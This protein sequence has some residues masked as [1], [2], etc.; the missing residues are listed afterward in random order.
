MTSVSRVLVVLLG[1][2]FVAGAVSASADSPDSAVRGFLA[3][4]YDGRFDELPKAPAARTERFERQVRNILRVRYI[5]AEQVAITG[6]EE[7]PD[8]ATLHADVAIAKHDRHGSGAWSSVEIVPLRFEL[9]RQGETWLVAE[10]RNRD[11]ELADHLLQASGEERERLRRELPE[12]PSRGL[13]RA[14]YARVLAYL[15]SGAFKEAAD[16]SAL[17]RQVAIEA[18]D[19]GGEALALGAATYTSEHEEMERLSLESLAIAETVGDPDVRARAWYDRGRTITR[20]GYRVPEARHAEVLE[21]YRKARALAEHAEDPSILIRILY[22]LGNIAANR[23]D[24]LSARRYIDEGLSIAREVGDVTGEMG[25]EM[26]LGTVYKGQGDRERALFHHARATEL[27]EKTQA[28]AYPTLLV[29]WGC[30]LVDLGRFDEARAMFDRVLVR[31]ETGMTTRMKSMPGRHMGSGLR[32]L[33]RIEAHNGNFAE[34]ECLNQESAVHD[35]RKANQYLYELAPDYASRGNHA[36]A[37]AASLAS[38]AQDRLYDDQRAAALVLAG[39]AYQN[40][41]FADRGLALALEAIELREAIDTRIAGDERQRAFAASITSDSYELAAELTL[42][43]GDPA[44]ALALLER[45]RARVLTGILENGRPGAA[46]EIDAEVVEQQS[47]LDREVARIA[48]ELDRV[49]AADDKTIGDLTERLNR[50]RNLR[51]S[52]LDG[53][54]ARSERRNAVR[55]RI[56]A[57]TVTSLAGR[58][59]P[60]TVAVEYFVG[61]HDLYIFVLGGVAGDRAVR[62]RTKHVERTVLDQRVAVFLEMLA[63]SDLRVEAPAR[64]L[65]A[66]LIEPVERDIAGADGLLV[67]PDDSLWSVPFAALVDGRGR[68]L[69]E[70]KATFY[71]S[72]MTAWSSIEDGRKRA[73][74]APVSLLAIANPTLDA[75]AGKVA[76]S[77]YRSATLGPLPDAEHEVDALRTFYDRRQ[78]VVLKRDLATEARTKVALHD[79]T[80]V[81]FATHAILDDANPMYS[82]LM[83]ARDGNAVEDGWLESWEVARLDLNA[84]LVVLA[85]CETARGGA[86][87]GEGVVGLSWSFFLAGASS[88]LASQW[89]VASDSTAGFMI[90]FHR[91]LRAPAINPALHKAQA[92]RDAQLQCI[93]NKRTSHPF[94][95]APFVLL[96]DPSAGT[97]H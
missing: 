59:P 93:R 37:L 51:A 8:Q 75:A 34:A 31:T 46:G 57:A 66:L 14:L 79:A 94:Y 40:L 74:S 61:E 72:S 49:Q 62:V 10:V 4:A 15:N 80:V 71:A 17:T 84:D 13:A 2:V 26:V 92:V 90:A 12:R 52:F 22:S 27:A 82:R 20:Q 89:K 85:A 87:G 24:Y 56:D 55:H 45:G 41:G 88:T 9:V 97:G 1:I 65:Y 95:W 54:S 38:L 50:A 67:V 47:V 86:R 64:E 53:V 23:A 44:G 91:S 30:Q 36:S 32:A 73:K 58:L 21:W 39:R 33:A 77:F 96:G 70:S 68:F 6:V 3:L 78:S 18:G 25:L 29:S 60:R 48:A 7:R 43:L 19:R 63:N 5:R 69:V 81:H 35:D 83:L 11:D 76:A 42:R 28:L 16:A